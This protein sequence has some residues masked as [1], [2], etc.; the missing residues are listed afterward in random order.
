MAEERGL[1][2]QHPRYR[3]DTGF[4]DKVRATNRQL[5]ER[6]IVSPY[7][8]RG[9]NVKRGQTFRVIEE[10]GPQVGDVAFWNAD[11]PMETLSCLRTWEVDG[12]WLKVDGRLWSDVPWFRPMV[13]C[14]EDTTALAKGGEEAHY[15]FVASHCSPESQ[16]MRSG[17]AGLNSCRLNLLQ[18]IE[19]FG[20]SEENLRENI[21]VFTRF[22]VD[23]NSGKLYGGRTEAD[24]GDYIEFYAEMDLLV[25]LSVCPTGD[26]STINTDVL[27]PLAI[28][29]YDT[30][31]QPEEFPQ[32]SDWRHS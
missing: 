23:P 3:V 1:F 4:Y 26:Y 14:I 9:F 15:H 8:G 10:E 25:A 7:N 2:F 27:W 30:D 16:E 32:W 21:D 18:A 6:F 19:P 20:L 5:V 22:F 11:N 29:I 12:W 24:P 13:T 17:R 28:E 31:I